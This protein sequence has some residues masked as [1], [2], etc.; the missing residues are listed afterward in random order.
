MGLTPGSC[1]V[2]SKPSCTSKASDKGDGLS[3]PPLQSRENGSFQVLRGAESERDPEHLRKHRNRPRR[4]PAEVPETPDLG[5]GQVWARVPL[6]IRG[7]VLSPK[8]FHE[9]TS[10]SRIFPPLAAKIKTFPT[11]DIN[12]FHISICFSFSPFVNS[13]ANKRIQKLQIPLN[14][15]PNPT[16]A[17]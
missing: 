9:W 3:V 6:P 7:P 16:R 4:H 10:N 2:E 8:P 11:N 14:K 5:P 13:D 15:Y 17:R 12:D 1:L